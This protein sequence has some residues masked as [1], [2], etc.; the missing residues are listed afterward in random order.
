MLYSLLGGL[1]F[2]RFVLFRIHRVLVELRLV[3]LNLRLE[4]LHGLLVVIG[5]GRREVFL[6]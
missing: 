2:V 4:L 1:G 3:L 6:L 5:G